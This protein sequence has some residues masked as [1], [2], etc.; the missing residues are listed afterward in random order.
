MLPG[1]TI[2]EAYVRIIADGDDLPGSVRREMSKAEP[3]FTAQGAKASKAYKKG[4]DAE[5]ARNR[6]RSLR[7]MADSI[8]IG[9]G[10]ADAIGKGLASDVWDGMRKELSKRT[11]SDSL[12]NI[13]TDDLRDAFRKGSTFD[14]L[15]RD[16]E[17]NLGGMT[18]DATRKLQALEKEY[19]RDREA[20][21]A[22]NARRIR[23][24]EKQLFDELDFDF[25]RHVKDASRGYDELNAHFQKFVD[26]GDRYVAGEVRGRGARRELLGDIGHLRTEFT[27][28]QHVSGDALDFTDELRT[29]EELGRGIERGRP[30]FRGL[31]NDIERLGD[32]VGITFGR[33]SRNNFVNFFGSLIGNSVRMLSIGPKV[34]DSILGIGRSVSTF[35]SVLKGGGGLGE[36]LKAATAGASGLGASAAAAGIGVAALVVILPVLISILTLLG[37]I[38]VALAGSITFG[39]VAGIAAL[40]GSIAPAVLGLGVLVAGI[41]AMDDQTK[42]A[43]KESLRPLSNEFKELG[44]IG[45]DEIFANIDKQVE[46]LTT[47]LKR[48]NLEGLVRGVGRSLSGVGDDIADG[49]DSPAFR[50]FIQTLRERMPADIRLLGKISIGVFGGL[51]GLLVATL[52]L[53]NDFLHGVR[54]ITDEFSAWANSEDGRREIEAFLARASKSGQSLLELLD[55]IGELLGELLTAGQDTGDTIIDQMAGKVQELTDYLNAHPDAVKEFFGDVGDFATQLGNVILMVVRLLDT[56]DSPASRKAATILFETFAGSIANLS[57]AFEQLEKVVRTSWSVI[58]D[59]IAVGLD[60]VGSASNLLGKIP[61][62]PDDLGDGAK[63]AADKLHGLA[64]NLRDPVFHSDLKIDVDTTELDAAGKVAHTT[65][66]SLRILLGLPPIKPKVDSSD[67][68]LGH[69]GVDMLSKDFK[70]FGQL[71]GAGAK[72]KVNVKE[73]LEGQLAALKAKLAIQEVQGVSTKNTRIKINAIEAKLAKNF[74]DNLNNS[75]ARIPRNILVKVK[76]ETNAEGKRISGRTASAVGGILD[77]YGNVHRDRFAFGGILSSQLDTLRNTFAEAGREAIVPLDRPLGQVD[78]SVRY[79]SAIAQGFGPP[80]LQPRGDLNLTLITPTKDPYAV[81]KEVIT[82][83]TLGGY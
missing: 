22:E 33:G 41:A 75:L 45:A 23:Q 37:G 29:I 40:A 62:V 25:E 1:E 44:K 66:E 10:K 50:T 68:K 12:G 78:P 57:W 76:V 63:D 46:K 83:I 81:G 19:H 31:S 15:R 67:L 35:T 55:N 60:A 20:A 70:G 17:D 58:L 39:L 74:V 52:P 47:G 80:E 6:E 30:R 3:E 13:I 34:I 77:G 36:A 14:D 56:L 43:L 51:G 5:T 24:T 42:K 61:G 38:V 26:T 27:K 49:V 11:G 7:T 71:A 2:G 18:R 72:P 54:D 82:E 53:V 32:K 21:Y 28:L 9:S 59:V 4:F 16:L 64:D 79:L 73:L 69:Q 65:D 8:T 48:S